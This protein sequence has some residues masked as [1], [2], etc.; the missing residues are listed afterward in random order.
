MFFTKMLRIIPQYLFHAEFTFKIS[1]CL[2]NKLFIFACVI[3]LSYKEVEKESK[4][5]EQRPK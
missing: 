4:Q 2:L 5:K 1:R 3:T